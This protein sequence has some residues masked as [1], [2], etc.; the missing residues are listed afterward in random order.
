MSFLCAIQPNICSNNLLKLHA[1]CNN[2]C[3]AQVVL[4]FQQ[5]RTGM[6]AT[7]KSTTS[8]YQTLSLVATIFVSHVVQGPQ[9]TILMQK[10]FVV[11][12]VVVVVYLP[13]EPDTQCKYFWHVHHTL[14]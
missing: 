7:T 5:H 11:I 6:N 13:E 1:F 4:L 12:V 10:Y 14:V 9:F 2:T 8:H 3:A